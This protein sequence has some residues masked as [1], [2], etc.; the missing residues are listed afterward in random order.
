MRSRMRLTC[1]VAI[2]SLLLVLTFVLPSYAC[3]SIPVSKE[4]SADGSTMT[5]HTCDGWYD[6]RTWV[7]PG[8]KHRAGEMMPVYR[9]LLHSDR[10][11]P[12]KIGEFPYPETTYNWFYAGYP[13]MNENQVIMGETTIG[14]RPELES[15]E[16]VMYIETLQIIGLQS[17]RTAREA[18]QLMG[19]AAEEYGY[20]D[21][22]ECLTV[23]DPNE[24]WHFEIMPPGTF[25]KGAI[26]AAVRIP[27]GHVGV[28]A[29]RSR[30]GKIDPNDPDNYMFSRNVFAVAEEN[31]WWDPKSGQEFLFYDAYNP[32]DAM[33]SRR[34][35]WRVLSWAAPSLKLDPNGSRFPFTVKAERKITIQDMM[36]I[37]R[38]TME[39]TEF[40]K[41]N[42][43]DWFIRDSKGN[44]V[45]S[46]FA[47]PHA[48][49]DLI[50]LLD[51]PN[52]RNISI[53][54]CSYHTILQA[55]GWLPN[56][57]GA[58]C[59]FG[60]NN[61]DTSVYVPIYAGVSSLP[62]NYAV[63]DRTKFSL[64]NYK[65][66][67]WWAFNFVDNVVNRRYQD[68]IK[69]LRAVRDPFEAEQF[70]KQPG[71]EKQAIELYAKDPAQ[72]VKFL[73]EYTAD[74]C[75]KAVDLFWRLVETLITKYDEKTF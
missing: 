66:S 23:G 38:D 60:L 62:A 9:G 57:V 44:S 29:N 28:S 31:G 24:V 5:A 1:V 61:P 70:A 35:E 56:G 42:D 52:E 22:G 11:P 6:A 68:M 10:T 41:A 26:W 47:T 65:E 2:L 51:L 17:A 7:V 58:I 27:E 75:A 13:Y 63:N 64:D 3:T 74:R 67:A 59:W 33:G 16:G 45:K 54:R 73:T 30:I 18:I 34:R 12:E 19:A 32:K 37:Y 21:A 49:S 43:P 25:K 14:N 48:G 15:T 72:A 50:A 55:R 4:A 69:D 39:G 46:P 8:G 71:I 20:I 40:D 53:P 36:K